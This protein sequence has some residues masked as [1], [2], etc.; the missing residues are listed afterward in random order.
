M[1]DTSAARATVLPQVRQFCSKELKCLIDGAFVSATGGATFTTTDPSTGDE[2]ARIARGGVAE[3]NA[4]V[5]AA[6][7]AFKGQAWRDMSFMT[8]A[9][10]LWRL[11]DLIERN[12]AELA[13]LETLDNGKSIRE[14]ENIDIPAAASWFRYFS[15][16]AGRI[17][18]Q[19]FPMSVPGDWHSFTLRE[20]VGVVGAII[21]WNFPLVVAAWKLAPALACGCTVVLKPA[22]ETSLTCLRLAELVVEAGFPPGVVNVVTG[23]GEE[24]GAALAAHPLV[25]KISFTGST[26]VGEKIV[27]ASRVNFKRL[28]LE[29]GGKSANIIFADAD[30]GTAIKVAARAGIFRNQGQICSAGSRILVQASVYDRAVE[31]IVKI[32]KS[33]KLGPG[34]ER[35]TQMGPLVSGIQL[36]RVL[37]FVDRAQSRDKLHVVAGGKRAAALPG[38]Y[39]IEP[40]V[41]ADVKSGSEI[42]QEEVF[43]PVAAMIRFEDE[44][45]ALAIANDTRYGLAAGVWTNDVR[46]AHRMVRRLKAGTVWVN[47][48]NMIDV[49]TPWGGTG[50]S[51]IGREHGSAAIDAFTEIKTGVFSLR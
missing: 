5:E 46:R 25:D 36:D 45:D 51:G 33:I 47:T 26:E 1:S 10:L 42:A 9:S 18:G 23:Y 41:L 7:R 22:E 16:A 28:T 39:F 40:T 43:G 34:L 48:Y 50:A 15:G 24:A 31:E 32:A 35:D 14:S 27:E 8:R 30:V 6:S 21:P 2:L 12:T 44:E 13:Q 19:T 38:G 37:G 3:I 17:E 20:P 11:A 4:A 49:T 29:L